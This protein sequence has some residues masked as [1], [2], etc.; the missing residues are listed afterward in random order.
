MSILRY[1]HDKCPD[2]VVKCDGLEWTAS[3][4]D[5]VSHCGTV[6]MVLSYREILIM[7]HLFYPLII[8]HRIFFF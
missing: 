3:K 1:H 2:A 5:T 8:P 4:T 6:S 7:L